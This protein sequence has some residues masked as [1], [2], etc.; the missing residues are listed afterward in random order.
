MNL[1]TIRSLAFLKCAYFSLWVNHSSSN[2][3]EYSWYNMTCILDFLDTT[4]IIQNFRSVSFLISTIEN[5][6]P[7]ITS[8][9][10]EI[11]PV[12]KF[13]TKTTCIECIFLNPILTPIQLLGFQLRIFSPGFWNFGSKTYFRQ[14]QIWQLLRFSDTIQN[15]GIGHISISDKIDWIPGIW[16]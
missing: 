3:D 10:D 6:S 15:L 16:S 7:N 1:T 2:S 5:L 12:N 8:Y 9:C 14:P 4:S 11:Y 13:R